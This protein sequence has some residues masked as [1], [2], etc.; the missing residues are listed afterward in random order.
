MTR[1]APRGD[2]KTLL[3]AF[4]L[5]APLAFVPAGSAGTCLENVD[6]FCTFED[7]E[8]DVHEC[9]V[10]VGLD[11]GTFACVPSQNLCHH[12]PSHCRDLENLI[13]IRP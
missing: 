1:P 8:G 6:T 5:L 9:A 12:A 13:Q 7:I 4:A 11:R 10:F 2:V 3:L